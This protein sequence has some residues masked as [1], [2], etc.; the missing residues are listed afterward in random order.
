MVPTPLKNISQNGNLPQIGVKIENI[1]N[2]QLGLE[3]TFDNHMDDQ[4]DLWHRPT[5]WFVYFGI[6]AEKTWNCKFRRTCITD[7]HI[8]CIMLHL[9]LYYANYTYYNYYTYREGA[10]H[11]RK[12][13]IDNK[14]IIRNK[15]GSHGIDPFRITENMFKTWLCLVIPSFLAFWVGDPNQRICL[16]YLQQAQPL[17]SN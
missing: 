10:F 1:W 5:L 15:H 4:R 3:D 2:H 6:N 13:W 16:E 11:H 9:C 12:T 8:P 17:S 7:T 14:M